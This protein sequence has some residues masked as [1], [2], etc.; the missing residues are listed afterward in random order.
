M[1]N[2]AMAR[3]AQLNAYDPS[4]R[5]KIAWAIANAL[6]TSRYAQQ[7][8]AGKVGG[9]LDLV[10]GLGI[11]LGADDTKRSYQ[12]GNY[13]DTALNLGMTAMG[14]IPGGKLLGKAA[15]EGVEN[16]LVPVAKTFWNEI[17]KTK[18][19]RP[20]EEMSATYR[21]VGEMVPRRT[22]SPEELQGSVLTPAIGDR[23][24]AGKALTGVN[25]VPFDK[26]V[27]L[28]GGPNFMR[29]A[30]QQVD[31]SAWA[32]GKGVISGLSKRIQ[33]L[34]E[35]GKDVNFLR[36]A[37]WRTICRWVRSTDTS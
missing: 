11:A 14:A 16:G 32:S 27:M 21:D 19:T 4:W 35:G 33:R 5:D 22:I 29:G 10:P 17:G 20:I 9:V 12:E 36:H 26:E 1:A 25:G 23:T 24:I 37:T 30:Q 18:L 15:R 3:P 7:D 31:G 8:I 28:Q 2:N 6:G 13:G 34:G